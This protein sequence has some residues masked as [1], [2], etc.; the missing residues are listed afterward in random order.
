MPGGARKISNG[1][2]TD[3]ARSQWQHGTGA[4]GGTLPP[5]KWLLFA[6]SKWRLIAEGFG[7]CVVT[8]AAGGSKSSITMPKM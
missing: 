5:F 4:P 1:E 2:T 3:R 8:G 7:A 6:D